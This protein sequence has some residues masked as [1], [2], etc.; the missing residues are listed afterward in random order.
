MR[1]VK[2]PSKNIKDRPLELKGFAQLLK[3]TADNGL[4]SKVSPGPL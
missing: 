1:L 2:C 3:L 4:A